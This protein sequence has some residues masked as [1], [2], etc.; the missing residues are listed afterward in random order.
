MGSESVKPPHINNEKLVIDSFDRDRYCTYCTSTVAASARKSK[1]NTS[2][3]S[4]GKTV[5]LLVLRHRSITHLGPKG[6]LQYNPTFLPYCVKYSPNPVFPAGNLPK[7]STAT[8]PCHRYRQP[9]YNE[10]P[11]PEISLSFIYLPTVTVGY[12]TVLSPVCTPRLTLEKAG[13]MK[14]ACESE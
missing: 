1:E 6:S 12:R 5:L 2:L 3:H 11:C 7:V 9:L 8:I 4:F 10:Q 13:R 14:T